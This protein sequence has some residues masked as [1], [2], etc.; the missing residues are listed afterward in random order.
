LIAAV[1]LFAGNLV[2]QSGK[3][4]SPPSNAAQ[5]AGQSNTAGISKEKGKA[6]GEANT[7]PAEFSLT[8][9]GDF[10]QPD[11][12]KHCTTALDPKNPRFDRITGV[13]RKDDGKDPKTIKLKA[14]SDD[15]AEI[16]FR[17]PGNY[18]P[19]WLVLFAGKR[20]YR[21]EIKMPP[22]KARDQIHHQMIPGNFCAL[23]APNGCEVDLIALEKQGL[24]GEVRK[25]DDKEPKAI[26]VVAL[27]PDKAEISFEAPA[28]YRPALLILSTNK[29]AFTFPVVKR[30]QPPEGPKHSQMIAGDYCPLD[31]SGGCAVSLDGFKGKKGRAEVRTED[32]IDPKEVR[33]RAPLF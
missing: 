27:S 17:A 15:S 2:S 13:V 4:K 16:S 11:C 21:F 33:K 12:L 24:K 9:D 6:N 7:A 23:A 10:C 8:V 19:K 32:G 30:V 20:S 29:G 31:S 26:K 1:F 22:E 14:L 3:P 5:A 28:D 25:D 18:Q